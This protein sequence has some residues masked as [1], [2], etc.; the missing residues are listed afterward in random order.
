[1]LPLVLVVLSQA[2][3]SP[4]DAGLPEVGEAEAAHEAR[5]KA[6]EQRL[7]AM[8]DRL[9]QLEQRSADADARVEGVETK[10]RWLEQLT[11]KFSGYLDVGF[12]A[13]Q[14]DGSGVRED[15]GHDLTGADDILRSWRL[16][17]DPLS[18]TIN[19]RGDVASTG[20]S[21]AVLYDPVHAGNKP[22]F[23]LNA[24]NVSMRA[25][26]G[27]DWL[28]QLTFDVLPRDRDVSKPGFGLGDFFDIKL[29]FLKFD[30][31]LGFVKLSLYAG[32]VDSL[33]GIEYR[34]QEANARLTISPSL[35]C[36]Y[37]CGHP[38]GLKAQGRFLDDA[39]EVWLALTNGSHQ[40]EQFPF[41]DDVDFNSGKTI[42]AKLA[43]RL[44][45]GRMLELTASGAI[46]PQDRQPSNAVWQWHYGFSALL[47][48]SD[49]AFSGE[50]VM[51]RANGAADFANKVTIPC[52]AATCLDYRGAYGQISQR[53]YMFKPYLR[54]D[55]RRANLRKGLDYA[56][57]S[58]DVRVTVGTRIDL[59]PNI[60]LKAEYTFNHEL[61]PY[62]FPDDV[63][64][65][66]L[67]VTY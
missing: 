2:V 52:G 56:Y 50:F 19:S 21:R 35:L 10:Q 31:D 46:G 14:G 23:L 9:D 22:T 65:S 51:G 20:A 64:T 41:S 39:L 42:A 32:K 18:T 47:L 62:D 38:V 8:Q 48:V 16:V 26:Y 3:S 36:R 25:A 30:H 63:F 28:A 1:M 37:T 11:V 66:S 40:S 59:T 43:V 61:F 49:F 60:V 33:L 67:V 55:W 58:D 15:Y 45:V 13:V 17:G 29:A 53:I 27:E 24:F 57:Q 4:V 44:P 12:F 7:E 5:V 54:V 34:A 6:L